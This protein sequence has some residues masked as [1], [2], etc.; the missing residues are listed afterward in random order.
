LFSSGDLSPLLYSV[1]AHGEIVEAMRLMQQSGHIGK[2][3]VRPPKERPGVGVRR[4]AF[5]VNPNGTHLITGGLAGFGLAAALWLIERGARHL[6][7]VGRS[8]AASEEAREAVARMRSLGAEVLVEALDIADLK[9]SA[10]L[11]EKISASMPPLAGVMH[12]ATVHD[13][14]IVANMD[15]AR[16]LKVLRPKIAGAEILD[17]LT[18]DM[19]LDYFVLFSSATTI[20]GN[21]GQGG[22]VAANGFLEGLARRRR[23]AGR[24]ALAIAWGAIS[25][26]GVLARKSGVRDALAARSGVKGM[27]ARTALNLMADALS[28][29]G[30]ASGGGVMI[31]ADMNWSTAR[32][33][34]PLLNSPTYKRLLNG[35]GAAAPSRNVVDLG[36]LAARLPPDEARRE[37]ANVIIEELARIL[38]L[39]REDVSK[40]KPLSDI[41]LDSL[42]AV[43]LTLGLEER[44]GL[45]APLSGLAGGFNVMELAGQVLAS[46]GHDDQNSTVAE[47]LAAVHLDETERAEVGEFI[48]ALQKSGVDLTAAYSPQSATAG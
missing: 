44:F 40:T 13:D 11:F 14:A 30:E 26:V 4:H 43:E 17:Q 42:M 46:Q 1:F 15:E 12:A 22:Y 35:E 48:D 39:P 28:L 20:I 16:L 10:E 33:H 19:A 34:L 45:D 7:L 5:S 41:G 32:A 25:D 8:G 3:L 37:V 36:E 6:V 31:I 24:P 23:Q 27:D 38:R 9:S 47:S 2:I 21:P 29:E 18:R